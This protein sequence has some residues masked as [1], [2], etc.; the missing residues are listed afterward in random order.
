M[1]TTTTLYLPRITEADH[2]TLRDQV[3]HIS[4]AYEEWLQSQASEIAGWEGSGGKVV[5]IDV[6]PDDLLLYCGDTGAQPNIHTFRQIAAA[7][8]TGKFR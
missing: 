3:K 1:K 6:S 4:P 7:K 8:G 5:L 2:K